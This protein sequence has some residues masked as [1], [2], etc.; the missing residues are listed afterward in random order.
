VTVNDYRK[1]LIWETEAQLALLHEQRRNLTK[2]I[3]QLQERLE[4]ER[5]LL[6]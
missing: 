5:G 2:L 4:R 1:K 6:V 3:G